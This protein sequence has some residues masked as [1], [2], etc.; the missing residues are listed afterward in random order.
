MSALDDTRLIK[1]GDFLSIQILKMGLEKSVMRVENNG[2]VQ[3]PFLAPM[4][5]AGLTCRV[6]AYHIKRELE[7]NYLGGAQWVL[8]KFSSSQE[9][10][11][12]LDDQKIIQP[13]DKVGLRI[14]EAGRQPK[15]CV[16]AQD[17][18]IK[19]QNIGR[20]Q[21]K[22]LTCKKLAQLISQKLASLPATTLS[23]TYSG[24][25]TV[26]IAFEVIQPPKV[27]PTLPASLR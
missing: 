10:M 16:L 24:A 19:V 14:L 4:K 22:G 1:E 6:L 8:V 13:G 26:V 3:P 5:A 18:T 20:V 17:G 12:V 11:N 27:K 9:L 7:K 15:D 25:P 23:Y 21:A 2:E